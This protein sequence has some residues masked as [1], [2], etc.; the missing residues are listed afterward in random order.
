V[1]DKLFVMKEIKD[2]FIMVRSTQKYK[3]SKRKQAK[4]KGFSLSQYI[5]H[6]MDNDKTN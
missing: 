3:D 5:R 1:Y 2:T 4:R 6:L